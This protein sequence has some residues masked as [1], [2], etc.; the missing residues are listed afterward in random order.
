MG[1]IR[2]YAKAEVDPYRIDLEELIKDDKE[3]QDAINELAKTFGVVSELSPFNC[4]R[5]AAGFLL[6]M[7]N[8]EHL[9]RYDGAVHLSDGPTPSTVKN[10]MADGASEKDKG[11]I[12]TLR[13][14]YYHSTGHINQNW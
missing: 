9:G 5:L 11:V 12:E 1:N 4:R 7:I 2:K 6:G 10:M 14:Q 8:K 3:L 13:E